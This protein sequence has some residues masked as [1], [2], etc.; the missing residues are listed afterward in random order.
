MRVSLVEQARQNPVLKGAN[1]DRFSVLKN[2]FHQAWFR[3]ASWISAIT[4]IFSLV[5]DRIEYET[6]FV[7]IWVAL[8]Y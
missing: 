6:I 8:R 1:S 4:A 7:I 3:K 2:G 5:E